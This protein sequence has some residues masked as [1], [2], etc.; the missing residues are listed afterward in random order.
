MSLKVALIHDWFTEP[1]GAEKVIERILKLYPQCEVFSIVDFLEAKNRNFL[2]GKFV[3]TSFIQKL[4]FAKTKYRTYLPLMPIAVEQ[5]D[6]S[7][8]DLIISSSSCVAK[9]VITGPEQVHISYCH[10]PVRYAWDLQNQYLK[11][12]NLDKGLK[13]IFAKL[14][15]HKIRN[16]DVISSNGVDYFIANSEFIKKR[17]R[18][19]YRREAAVIY[20]NVNVE[21]FEL[22]EKK[23][24]YYFT[25]SRM[26]PYKKIALIAESFAK[27]PNK[28]L[29]IIGDGPDMAKVKAFAAPNIVIMGYQKFSVL[30]EKMQ[31]AKAFIFAAQEDFGIVPV[32][33]Q[34]CGTPVI[35][36]GKGGALETVVDKKTGIYFNNQTCESIIAAVKSFEN[37]VLL[38]PKLIREHA[39]KFSE[40][41]FD[42][43]FSAFVNSKLPLAKAKI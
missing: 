8:F 16:W 2:D 1:G 26:V 30:K 40:C 7:K 20:P 33:A 28:K 38:E 18:K 23:E 15:L 11:E 36:F 31:K 17:I 41:R 24:D 25:A 34:A 14:I 37:T 22:C 9:G 13:S 4:P 32:E 5:F 43:E 39:L 29:V 42:S 21:E 3:N 19:V 35:A 10:S 27:M 6:L 12:S